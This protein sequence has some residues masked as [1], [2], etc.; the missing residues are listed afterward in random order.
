[1]NSREIAL[2]IESRTYD[3]LAEALARQQKTLDGELQK[4]LQQL[5][6]QTIPTEQRE[7]IEEQ[8]R[9]ENAAREQER[10]ENQRFSVFRITDRGKSVCIK[11]NQPLTFLQAAYQTRRFLWG[12]MGRHISS[13]AGYFMQ[14]GVMIT[15][16]DFEELAGQ[17]IGRRDNITGVF[18]IDLDNKEFAFADPNQGWT[19]YMLSDVTT[20]VYYAYRKEHRADEERWNI[21]YRKLEGREIGM[22]QNHSQRI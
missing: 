19:N 4:F 8:I 7:K 21:L 15:S 14:E 5:C 20:A 2:W 13:L 22:E 18:D 16:S 1:M 9:V 6:E 10:I 11:Y 3:A 17:R 12:E